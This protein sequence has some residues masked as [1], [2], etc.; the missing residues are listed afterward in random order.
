MRHERGV[1]RMIKMEGH[2]VKRPLKAQRDAHVRRVHFPLFSAPSCIWSLLSPS[3]VPLSPQSCFVV[4][5]FLVL[6]LNFGVL[7]TQNT[8]SDCRL[9]EINSFWC[10][11][12]V[13]EC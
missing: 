7:V 9:T 12:S 2:P 4:L 11:G 3:L 8:I 13:L 6:W 5:L 1:G 10:Y